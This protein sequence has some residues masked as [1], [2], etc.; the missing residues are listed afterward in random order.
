MSHVGNV[1]RILPLFFLCCFPYCQ[2]AIL[3]YLNSQS[4]LAFR[5]VYSIIILSEIRLYVFLRAARA[6]PINGHVKAP[7]ENV[8]QRDLFICTVQLIHADVHSWN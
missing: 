1:M 4:L 8:L 2:C 7:L 3:A 6:P 5:H